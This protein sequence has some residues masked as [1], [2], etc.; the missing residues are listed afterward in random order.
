MKK[1]CLIILCSIVASAAVTGCW[2]RRELNDLA[3]STAMGLDKGKGGNIIVTNQ[4]LYPEA[5][6]PKD[7]GGGQRA[8]VALME[9]T[10]AGVQQAVRKMTMKVSK[11]IYVGHVQILVIGEELARSGIIE[12]LEHYARDHEYRRDFYVIVAKGAR[13]KDIL[14]VFTPFES[15]PANKLRDSLESSSKSWGA[16]AAI[17]F[18]ELLSMLIAK[19][20]EPILTGVAVEGKA[21]QGAA[22]EN[23]E[24]IYV[25]TNLEYTG[26]AVFKNDK[27]VGWLNQ[28]DSLGV[29]FV[30]GKVKSSNIAIPCPGSN[31]QAFF[32][33][34][35][36]NAKSKVEL[37]N[38]NPVIQVK[39]SGEGNMSDAKCPVDMTKQDAIR[40]ME[41]LVNK[42]VKEI[43]ESSVKT[44]QK[45]YKS[46]I[47]GF[48]NAV[49]RSIPK[50]WYTVE[51]EWDDIF[52]DVRVHVSSDIQI[53]EIFKTKKTLP[54]RMKE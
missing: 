42:T 43:V 29:N 17:R 22:K 53:R 13:A 34:I 40:D 41:R 21:Q 1:T 46:D 5:V 54:E 6:S 10:E 14:K 39:V 48:G 8:P 12:T 2:N 37:K 20:R 38:G 35:R 50:Y 51:K 27:L 18:G 45:K 47:F 26:L 36:T 19:G 3:I 28:M 9:E 15:V 7:G 25:P 30:R 4:L 24:R 49:E 32:E 11:K 31:E 23:V 16:S 44:A 33:A 52:P